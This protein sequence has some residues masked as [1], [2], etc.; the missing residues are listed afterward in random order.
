MALKRHS[1][2]QFNISF[3]FLNY[4]RKMKMFFSPRAYLSTKFQNGFIQ[5]NR[6]ILIL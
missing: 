4:R 3:I 5:K 1:W 2:R 6:K